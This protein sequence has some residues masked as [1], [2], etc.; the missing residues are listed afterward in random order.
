MLLAIGRLRDDPGTYENFDFSFAPAD[1]GE[2][3]VLLTPVRAEGAVT[4]GGNA[5]LLSG[6]LKAAARLICSRCLADVQLDL[7]FDFEEEFDEQEYP[8]EDAELDMED[9][10]SQIW[11]SSIPMQVLCDDDCKGLCP[12]CGKNLN[13][14]D[15]DCP[16]DEAD[17]RLEALR[18]LLDQE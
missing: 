10:A 6:C 2:D 3:C 17:P 9:I 12:T 13:E 16:K 18:S 11:V 15:C 14:G 5:F 4:F 1:S 7:S 8:G